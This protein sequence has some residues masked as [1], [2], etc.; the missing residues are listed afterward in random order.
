MLTTR[1]SRPDGSRD[2]G[3]VRTILRLMPFV[4][5]ALRSIILAD[6]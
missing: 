1:P 2:L 6:T 3:T 4:R 5:P